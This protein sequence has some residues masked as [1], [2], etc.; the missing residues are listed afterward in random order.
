MQADT[1]AA[2]LWRTPV[3]SVGERSRVLAAAGPFVPRFPARVRL[4]AGGSVPTCNSFPRP[5]CGRA[6]PSRDHC[7]TTDRLL[8]QL[9]AF[10]YSFSCATDLPTSALRPSAR[11]REPNRTVSVIAGAA[12]ASLPPFTSSKCLHTCVSP[13]HG[14]RVR[15]TSSAPSNSHTLP[16]ARAIPAQA[17]RMAMACLLLLLL[18]AA[19]SQPPSTRTRRSMPLRWPPPASGLGRASPKRSAWT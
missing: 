5:P 10:V 16:H 17:T 6:S 1:T 8:S 18:P 13:P 4:P 7:T 9:C 15:S 14:P 19:S 12:S 2:S 11:R 3:I